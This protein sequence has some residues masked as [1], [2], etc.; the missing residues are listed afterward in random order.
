MHRSV[1]QD[2]PEDRRRAARD[3]R[4]Q[5]SEGEILEFAEL[6]LGDMQALTGSTS[7][8]PAWISQPTSGHRNVLQPIGI[9]ELK[10]LIHLFEYVRANDAYDADTGPLS[11]VGDTQKQERQLEIVCTL[12]QTDQP[13][14]D[15]PRSCSVSPAVPRPPDVP[16][17]F[18][19]QL[20]V[21]LFHVLL[22]GRA[23]APRERVLLGKLPTGWLRSTLHEGHREGRAV[24]T[25]HTG[26]KERLSRRTHRRPW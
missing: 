13:S 9:F 20:N 18:L 15:R 10:D 6:K 11:A 21:G 24:A 12:L 25:V 14:W 17:E 4:R 23:H 5:G 2:H 19:R 1:P 8:L 3:A 7:P 22:Q 16:Q 26:W